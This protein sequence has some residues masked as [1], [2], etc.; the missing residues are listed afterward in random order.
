M[1][2]NVITDFPIQRKEGTYCLEETLQQGRLSAIRVLNMVAA[3]TYTLTEEDKH[4]IRTISNNLVTCGFSPL[5]ID[6]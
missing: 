4:C 6:F 3:G 2:D 1:I 5:N